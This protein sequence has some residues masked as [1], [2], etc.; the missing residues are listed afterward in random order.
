MLFYLVYRD[1]LSLACPLD[2]ARGFLC[3][4]ADCDY[5]EPLLD[6]AAICSGLILSRF[7]AMSGFLGLAQT[8]LV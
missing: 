7:I 1:G 4:L 3:R 5:L 2:C 8:L 6:L